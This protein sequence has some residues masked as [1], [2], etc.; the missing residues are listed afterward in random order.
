[1]KFE[2]LQF[3]YTDGLYDETYW[4]TA[5]VNFSNGNGLSVIYGPHALCDIGFTYEIAIL[6]NNLPIPIH[7][8]VDSRVKGYVDPDLITEILQH[9]ENS[10]PSEYLAWIEE[11]V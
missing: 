9:A 1:M 5:R 8:W 7:G 11:C 4:A 2:D 10:T 3:E 6:R